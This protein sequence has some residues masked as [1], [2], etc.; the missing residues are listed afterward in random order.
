M[1]TERGEGARSDFSE[2]RGTSE[3][4]QPPQ[5]LILC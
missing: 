4:K 1:E 5:W 2:G 3:D